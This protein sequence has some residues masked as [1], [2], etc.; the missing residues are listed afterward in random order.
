MRFYFSG[1]R[2]LLSIFKCCG[3]DT[4]LFAVTAPE[5]AAAGTL[6][7]KKGSVKYHISSSK[8]TLMALFLTRFLEM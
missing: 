5:A 4:R 1:R 6:R 3:T 2:I 8:C 7:E